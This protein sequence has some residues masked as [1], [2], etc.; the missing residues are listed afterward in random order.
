MMK[1]LKGFLSR[2]LHSNTPH[3]SISRWIIS[4]DPKSTADVEY[5]LKEYTRKGNYHAL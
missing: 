3:D 1:K 5:W 4:K 2:I